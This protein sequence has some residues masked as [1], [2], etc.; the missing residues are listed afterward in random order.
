M[1]PSKLENWRALASVLSS[2][3]AASAPGRDDGGHVTTRAFDEAE[4]TRRLLVRLAQLHMT[5]GGDG[6]TGQPPS[7][8]SHE[9]GVASSMLAGAG[10][11]GVTSP[12][13][14]AA[15]A[16]EV[17]RADGGTGSRRAE[18]LSMVRRVML[19]L[20]RGEGD[21]EGAV[22]TLMDIAKQLMRQGRVELGKSVVKAVGNVLLPTLT[23]GEKWTLGSTLASNEMRDYDAAEEALAQAVAA[24][25]LGALPSLIAASQ[26][27]CRWDAVREHVERFVAARHSARLQASSA[28]DGQR[29]RKKA[30]ASKASGLPGIKDTDAERDAGS[31]LEAGLGAYEVLYLDVELSMLRDAAEAAASS[32]N[33]RALS[34]ASAAYYPALADDWM[35]PEPGQASMRGG[36][37]TVRPD[38][39]SSAWAWPSGGGAAGE[40]SRGALV[41]VAYMSSD[42][43]LS[44]PIGQLLLPV[45]QGHNSRRTL[46]LC[47]DTHAQGLER[48]KAAWQ[49]QVRQ[50]CSG[51]Y[52]HLHRHSALEAAELIN[53]RRVQVLVN[54][55]GW[56]GEDRLDVLS[57]RP[58]PLQLNALGYAGTSCCSFIDAVLSDAVS[59]PPE[60]RGHYSEA[61]L[62]LPPSHHVL[63]HKAIYGDSQNTP[64]YA[65]EALGLPRQQPQEQ[66]VV[67]T[68]A[69]GGASKVGEGAVLACFN[70]VKKIDGKTWATWLRILAEV[71]GTV[72]WLV[73]LALSPGASLT[74]YVC[75]C[76]CVSVCLPY[77]MVSVPHRRALMRGVT[78]LSRLV[79]E[80]Q[81]VAVCSTYMCTRVRVGMQ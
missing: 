54:L 8:S 12:R 22:G 33:E 18:C 11:S 77:L 2:L 19:G 64:P 16:A 15:M 36:G 53:Q 52:V 67:E 3:Q 57:Y 56:A 76:V 39:L 25:Q 30:K 69:E 35:G 34:R 20:L 26:T 14:V 17:M 10:R 48:S 58:A 21:R 78:T 71:P 63:P 55:N 13:D 1:A 68:A 80:Q 4:R 59:A 61:L 50:A 66:T 29:S 81:A 7:V 28:G 40:G 79:E 38:V 24:G 31:V 42:I 37:S 49:Q 60:L 9:G 46:P 70:R 47:I 74:R 27:N 6:S 73:R 23:P 44:H 32:L 62:L 5:Q 41:V 43:K 72:L 51:G 45:L 75:L 65:R